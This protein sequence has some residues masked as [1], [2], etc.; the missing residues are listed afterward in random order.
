MF[1]L[2][3]GAEAEAFRE[4]VRA[5]LAGN[6][7]PLPD[8]GKAERAAHEAA[9]RLKAIEAGYLYRGIPRRY[10]GS[11][12]APDVVRAQVIREEFGRVR[13]PM[14][15]RGNGL[16]MFMPTLLERGTPEQCA[17]FIPPTVRG[18]FVWAQGYSEPGTGSDLASVRT[19]GVLDGDEWVINGHKIWSTDGLHATHMFALVR[20]EPDAGKH[21][22]ISYLLIDLDQ[23]G[24]TRRPI[25]QITGGST[26]AEFFLDD[27]RTPAHW[28]VGGR[29]EGWSVSRA[30]LRHERASIGSAEAT[31]AQFDKLVALARAQGKLGDPV[32]RDGL[33]RIEGWI[34]S[35]RY[36]N[37]RLFSLAASGEEPG[38]LGAMMKLMM[39]EIGHDVAM[40]AMNLLGEAG[41]LEPDGSGRGGRGPERWLD[42]VMGSLGMSIAGGTTNIQRNIIAERCL[43]LPRGNDA[44]RNP[45]SAA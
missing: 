4:T 1:D 37:F 14:E 43:G 42:Q 36:S 45:G 39:S 6:W 32:V 35:H 5:F 28:I 26:F 24:V 25:R 16:L 44:G 38:N 19:T 30:T 34:A 27:V 23:P 13:A 10:G 22:G 2:S 29:G 7:Q 3:Y 33:A 11:E 8:A 21:A 40:M 9:F 15:I 12:Q 17:R 31:T 20:T 41:M 18:E